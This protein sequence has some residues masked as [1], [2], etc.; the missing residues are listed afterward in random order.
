MVIAIVAVVILFVLAI[1]AYGIWNC[2]RS[3]PQRISTSTSPSQAPVSIKARAPTL[4][5]LPLLLANSSSGNNK[6][7]PIVRLSSNPELVSPRLTA[8]SRHLTQQ[9]AGY[10]TTRT[11]D[12]SSNEG[13]DIGLTTMTHQQ[14]I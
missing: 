8:R 13:D 2:A 10:C 4:S 1:F 11:D 6:A 7:R 14:F 3:R 9:R 12:T 5:N